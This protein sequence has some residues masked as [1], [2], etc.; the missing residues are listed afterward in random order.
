MAPKKKTP[1]PKKAAAPAA[2]KKKTSAPSAAK[3]QQAKGKKASKKAEP[4]PSKKTTKEATLFVPRPKNFGI[5]NDLKPR[6]DVTRFVR[7]PNYVRQQ[8]QKAVLLRRMKIPPAI[9]QFS[10]NVDST[11]KKALFKFAGKYRKETKAARNTRLKEEAEAKVKDPKAKPSKKSKT[12]G[13]FEFITGLSKITRS[14]EQKKAKLVLIANDVDPIELVVW[15]P[16]LCKKMEVPYAIVK[17]KAALG[18]LARFKKASSIAFTNIKAE[19][20]PTFEKLCATVTHKFADKY[21]DAKKKWGGLRLGK[22]HAIKMARRA[23]LL[24]A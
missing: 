6:H 19:D 10:M 17:N 9:N 16:A 15:L 1:P 21:E 4:A 3:K 23:A 11:T 8:R 18:R 2:A 20:K 13:R 22:K 24:K 14:I 12:A 7:W 5:G